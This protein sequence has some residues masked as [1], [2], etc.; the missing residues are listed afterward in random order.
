LIS[1]YPFAEIHFYIRN[2]NYLCYCLSLKNSLY[3]G[4]TEKFSIIT[5][6]TFNLPI[7]FVF[8]ITFL[9]TEDSIIW[10]ANVCFKVLF[11]HSQTQSSFVF[12]HFTEYWS[13]NLAFILSPLQF[14]QLN[15]FLSNFKDEPINLCIYFIFVYI[16]LY[17]HA[18]LHLFSS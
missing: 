3:I 15:R 8:L 2:K 6:L 11:L 4:L 7:S 10:V 1:W 5:I 13:Q 12:M 18:S 17:E 9:F 14:S 16:Q